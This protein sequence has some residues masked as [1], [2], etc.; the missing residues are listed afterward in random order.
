MKATVGSLL[1]L[2]SEVERAARQ[3]VAAANGGDL[4]KSAYGLAA[5][6]NAWQATATRPEAEGLLGNGLAKGLRMRLQFPLD[7]RNGICHGLVGISAAF[8]SHPASLTWEIGEKRHSLAW[9][10]MQEVLRWLSKVPAA[11]SIIGNPERDKGASRMQDTTE[12]REW[13][14][15]EYGLVASRE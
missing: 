3:Q 14:L 10:E 1:L 7:I 4:P 2:W 5:A 9:D 8:H 13:W 12:N 15:A 11:L 6:L